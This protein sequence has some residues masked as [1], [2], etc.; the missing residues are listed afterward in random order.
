MRIKG[1]DNL[2][3]PDEY[4]RILHWDKNGE[5]YIGIINDSIII[6]KRDDCCLFCRSVVNLVRYDVFNV[7]RHCVEKLYESN[8]GDVLYKE[9]I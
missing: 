8:V 1:I 4:L 5:F 9:G 2:K 6:K 7:C 3:I